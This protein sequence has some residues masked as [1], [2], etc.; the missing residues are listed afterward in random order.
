M[1]VADDLQ[2]GLF[3]MIGPVC[4]G[5]IA[6]L[7]GPP[8]RQVRDLLLAGLVATGL[9]V[10]GTVVSDTTAPAAVLTFL[11]AFAASFAAIAGRRTV[12]VTTALTLLF[13]VASSVPASD[14]A[15]GPRLQGLALGVVA[16]ALLEV[17]LPDRA[18]HAFRAEL[19]QA[20]DGLAAVARRIAAGRRP[21]TA[22]QR[23]RAPHGP[24]S[25]VPTR[26]WSPRR[27][28]P[29]GAGRVE[30]AERLLVDDADRLAEDLAGLEAL[31]RQPAGPL[32]PRVASSWA[33]SPRR[34]ST[35][36]LCW[37]PGAALRAPPPSAR[38]R[39]PTRRT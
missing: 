5:A 28:D 32:R 18:Q 38:G 3:A 20:L 21:R 2:L 11:V 19:A 16:L 31:V 7:R 4:L 17:L 15:I 10:L 25:C 36:R 22:P 39:M 33:R 1:L 24:P 14:A 12:S 9:V 37:P 23:R 8:L 27:S 6:E 34:S 29:V 35:A 13:V 26:T 30:R